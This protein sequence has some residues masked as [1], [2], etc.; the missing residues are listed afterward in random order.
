MKLKEHCRISDTEI[1]NL[2]NMKQTTLNTK[3][4]KLDLKSGVM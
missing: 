1:A 2:L 3:L 4:K